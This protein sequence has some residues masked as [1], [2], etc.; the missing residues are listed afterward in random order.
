MKS[1]YYKPTTL[2]IAAVFKEMGCLQQI[3]HE[4]GFGFL[5]PKF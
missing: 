2:F 4:H 3:I 1:A 5:Q